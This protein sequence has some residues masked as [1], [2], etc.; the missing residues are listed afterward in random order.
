M[1]DGNRPRPTPA[2]FRTILSAICMGDNAAAAGRPIQTGRMDGGERGVSTD[3][4][5]TGRRGHCN[6]FNE[7]TFH[8]NTMINP[9]L[10]SPL[11]N[12]CRYFV[13]VCMHVCAFRA[14]L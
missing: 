9:P 1:S 12:R 7:F 13:P 3:E 2:R 4:D 8:T 14:V 5:R 11:S 10:S 6:T